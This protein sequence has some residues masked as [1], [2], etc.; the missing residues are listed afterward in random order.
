MII[1]ILVLLCAAILLIYYAARMRKQSGLP[2]GRI[3][4]S[5]VKMWGKPVEKPLFDGSIGLVGKPDYLIQQNGQV[6]PVEVK[7]CRPP[8]VPYDSHIYQLAAY[9][10]LVEKVYQSRPP[11]GL[12][13]Y[14]GRT[15]SIEFT[16]D[17]REKTLSLISEMH[18]KE[19]TANIPRSHEEP[20]RCR[21]CGYKSHCN[22][23]I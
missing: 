11:H 18:Q 5:D 23:R 19:R 6:I 12:I 10:L 20:G 4:Y 7:S 8:E 3:I 21:S 2:G 1:L 17:L 9:C 22:Q 16:P 14:P 15:F 13:H